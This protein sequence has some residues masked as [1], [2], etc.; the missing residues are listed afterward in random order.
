M[1]A[2]TPRSHCDMK[3][4]DFFHSDTASAQGVTIGALLI[5][6]SVSLICPTI[7]QSLLYYLRDWFFMNTKT[8]VNTV[9]NSSVH[10]LKFTLSFHAPER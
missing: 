4:K 10:A 3:V 1:L 7:K 8:W 2:D 6:N 5:E 9:S